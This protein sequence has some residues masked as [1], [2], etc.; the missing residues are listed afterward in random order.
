MKKDEK[1]D[2]TTEEKKNPNHRE[3]V[4]AEKIKK[5]THFGKKNGKE[6][7]TIN[8]NKSILKTSVCHY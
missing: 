2:Y 1:V 5:E 6:E 4:N 7:F 3:S 8:P